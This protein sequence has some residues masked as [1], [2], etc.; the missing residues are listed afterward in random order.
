M[1]ISQ[2][3]LTG[4]VSSLTL[5]A[6]SSAHAFV[7]DTTSNDVFDIYFFGNGEVA[8]LGENCFGTADLST[9]LYNDEIAA[10]TDWTGTDPAGKSNQWTEEQKRAMTEAV[11]VWTN[12]IQNTYGE[13]YSRKMRIGFFL[14]DGSRSES[15]MDPGMTGYARYA[16]TTANYKNET[17]VNT[18]SVAEWLWREGGAETVSPP[19]F[20]ASGSPWNSNLLP[21]QSN[22]I[23]IAIVVNPE[24]LEA[25]ELKK[26]A[27][28]EIAHA[29]GMDS[30]MYH[31]HDSYPRTNL[32]T[33]WDSLMMTGDD[34][35]VVMLENGKIVYAYDTFSALCSEGYS[36][37]QN[38]YKGETDG[39]KLLRLQDESGESVLLYVASINVEGNSLV[40][41]L[42]ELGE[43]EYDD[44]LGPTGL[45]GD[46]F[47]ELDLTALRLLGWS[48]IPEPSSF[49]LLAGT[50]ALLLAGARRKRK[51]S[52]R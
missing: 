5:L 51:V 32:V 38:W 10:W 50:V 6:A 19:S 24:G 22:C 48:V 28:H 13:E 17:P 41:L 9:G 44:V 45:Q 39:D 34:Q 16:R 12:T 52:L 2:S 33:T 27:M 7:A 35:R 1:Q 21:E 47:T 18:Y 15:L 3:F 36:L 25:D 49:G 43:S 31:M 46:A 40:H 37:Y 11:S 23:E 8:Q 42:G 26:V 20:S 30:T 29:M 14:D 4:A